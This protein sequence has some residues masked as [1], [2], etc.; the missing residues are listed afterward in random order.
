MA[1]LDA[2]S[3]RTMAGLF[4]LWILFF[5]IFLVLFGF[6]TSQAFFR[7]F[8]ERVQAH[9]QVLQSQ[10][11]L[12]ATNLVQEPELFQR[13]V[14]VDAA[15]R[16][17]RQQGMAIEGLGDYPV[18]FLAE[19][20]ELGDFSVSSFF[21]DPLLG[22]KVLL[23][24]LHASE[25]FFFGTIDVPALLSFFHQHGLG[26]FRGFL[27]DRFDFGLFFDS[28]QFQEMDYFHSERV[29]WIS[30]SIVFFQGN[31]FFF[32]RFSEF[33]SLPY[34]RLV[35][36]VPANEVL[37]GTLLPVLVPLPLGILLIFLFRWKMDRLFAQ[38]SREFR[39]VTDSLEMERLLPF[40][41]TV[42][43][44]AKELVEG[45]SVFVEKANERG[46]DVE[47]LVQ[48]VSVLNENLLNQAR[49]VTAVN[50]FLQRLAVFNQY[51]LSTA[52]NTVCKIMLDRETLFE[53]CNVLLGYEIVFSMHGVI[54][55][56]SDCEKFTIEHGRFS[57][58]L[59]LK[60]LPSAMERDLVQR[61]ELLRTS[62]YT[63]LVL[64][65]LKLENHFDRETGLLAFPFFSDL[66]SREMERV[67]RY[68]FKSVLGVARF[69]GLQEFEERYGG[70]QVH[71]LL[72][73]LGQVVLENTRNTDLFAR[74][75]VDHFLFFFLEME[76]AAAQKKMERLFETFQDTFPFSE[77]KIPIGIEYGLCEIHEKRG[78]LV[79][80]IREAMAN[81]PELEH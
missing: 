50:Q 68:G 59:L 16:L 69:S 77:E 38:R 22:K 27:F 13:V 12:L 9:A 44:E 18:R 7:D 53:E 41:E 10:F 33:D 51:T 64:Y 46:Q 2:P 26:E 30:K 71:R 17:I 42:D 57:V 29:S 62:L 73:H 61:R 11:E 52:L 43:D 35:E 21:H 31:F 19:I 65:S 3:A 32:S 55:N 74:Y 81:F 56:P 70:N 37:S 78:S 34:F 36:I 54:L 47:R 75:S 28:E 6:H 66:A 14:V 76:G 58:S 63:V 39:W 15:G 1:A 4:W 5:V 72:Q 60:P 8:N 25:G 48:K 20:P 49:Q 67:W 40:P 79:D 23:V 80:M 24:S 45:L